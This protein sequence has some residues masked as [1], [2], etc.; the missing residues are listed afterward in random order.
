MYYNNIPE[1]NLKNIHKHK[2]F[3]KGVFLVKTIQEGIN[4]DRFEY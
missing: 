3:L 2:N 1:L 4:I